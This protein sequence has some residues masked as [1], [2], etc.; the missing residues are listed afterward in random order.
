MGSRLG[1]GQEAVRGEVGQ[2]H[3]E[4]DKGTRETKPSLL[5][6]TGGV[7]LGAEASKAKGWFLSPL[8]CLLLNCPRFLSLHLFPPHPF[9]MYGNPEQLRQQ[10]IFQS[11]SR[12]TEVIRSWLWFPCP[13]GRFV[14]VSAK[15]LR[16]NPVFS[17]PLL[18]R[19]FS[20]ITL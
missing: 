11:L 13:V 16:K 15:D 6:G 4:R 8:T 10:L 1:S 3:Y 17:L 7:S 14:S 18:P 5:A 9:Y 20:R 2:G 19:F 12:K